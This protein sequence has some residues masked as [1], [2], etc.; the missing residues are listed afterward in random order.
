MPAALAMRSAISALGVPIF[1]SPNAMLS[2]AV[3]WG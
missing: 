2:R 3:M 1:L